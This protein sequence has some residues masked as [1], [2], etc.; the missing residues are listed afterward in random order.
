MF[1]D[2]TRPDAVI[3]P[4]S[5]KTGNHPIERLNSLA[6]HAESRLQTDRAAGERAH[7]RHA[8][9]GGMRFCTHSPFDTLLFP[10]DHPRAG[11]ERYRWERQPD[12]AELGYLV[13]DE[14]REACRAKV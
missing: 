12:G 4:D 11:Q 1:D 14:A 2:P 5:W 3:F 9:A 10:K 6:D 13:D 7:I 8:R